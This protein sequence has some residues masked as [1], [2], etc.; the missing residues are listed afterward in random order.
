MKVKSI[1]ETLEDY[2]IS[3]VGGAYRTKRHWI[4]EG[5]DE[6]SAIKK[7]LNWAYSQIEAGIRQKFTWQDAEKGF[8]EMTEIANVFADYCKQ[9]IKS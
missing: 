7:T 8:R 5:F 9:V 1:E 3:T 2:V 4:N 6:K